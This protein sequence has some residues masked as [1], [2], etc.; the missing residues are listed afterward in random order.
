MRRAINLGTDTAT[1]FDKDVKMA[2]D[3]LDASQ[4]N[5]WERGVSFTLRNRVYR[6]VWS[7][8]WKLFASWTP[9]PMYSWR[10]WLLRFFGAKI[11]PTARVYPSAQIWSPANLTVGE[12]A[13]IGPDVKVYSMAEVR[14]APYSLASQGAHIC[15]G[16]H[17]IE[18]VNFQ[19]KA[20]PISIG[21]RAWIAADAFVG[22]GVRVGDGA[23]LGA[24]SC[25]F[26]DL[27]PWTVYVGNPALPLKKRL[28]RFPQSGA[29]LTL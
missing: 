4:I 3:I 7:M 21:F 17:D 5:T 8:T 26:G 19:L 27:D 13:C 14:F 29:G 1:V 9:R 2:N 18:D 16:T 22:P 12:F 6:L 23:V 20:M 25:A 15:A 11:A 28:V 24:R 10:R